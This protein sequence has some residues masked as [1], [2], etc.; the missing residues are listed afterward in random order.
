M[1]PESMR[2]VADAIG[3]EAT[4]GLLFAYAGGR[5][6]VPNA[7]N[8]FESH[9]LVLAV[10]P[11]AAEALARR[12]GG[13]YLDVPRGHRNEARNREIM[14]RWRAGRAPEQIALDYGISWRQVYRIIEACTEQ[15]AT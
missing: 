13:Q 12:I 9:P 5:L 8:L 2:D 11:E 15:A 7:E 10:G 3:E 6:Y 14:R 1:I 4:V